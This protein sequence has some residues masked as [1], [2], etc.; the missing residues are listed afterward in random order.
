MGSVQDDLWGLIDDSGLIPSYVK[1]SI[2]N[3]AAANPDKRYVVC[4][5]SQS[6]SSDEFARRHG[7]TVFMIAEQNDSDIYGLRDD[8]EAVVKYLLQNYL[9]GCI[10]GVSVVGDT[11]GVF[12]LADGRYYYKF[13]L[14]VMSATS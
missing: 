8:A 14:M 4:R 9:K 7:F 11:A 6:Y 1:W 13:D 2:W 12:Q 3:D 10:I 5:N